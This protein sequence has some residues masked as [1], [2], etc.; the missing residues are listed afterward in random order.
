VLALIVPQLVLH[1]SAT[2]IDKTNG[3]A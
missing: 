2:P 3:D 1:F